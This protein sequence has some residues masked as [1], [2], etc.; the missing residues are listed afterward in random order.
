MALGRSDG[1]RGLHDFN[2]M[3]ISCYYTDKRDQ[4]YD[5]EAVVPWWSHKCS[6]LI[7]AR[8]VC[9]SRA[10]CVTVAVC[11][12]GVSVSPLHYSLIKT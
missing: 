6:G 9:Y 8:A 12:Q 10:L 4:A 11:Y 1:Y 5:M 7:E 2:Y 3:A